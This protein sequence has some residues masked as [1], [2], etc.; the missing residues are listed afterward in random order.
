MAWRKEVGLRRPCAQTK[1]VVVGV[2]AAILD[3]GHLNVSH[4]AHWLVQRIVLVVRVVVVHLDR[5]TS[6]L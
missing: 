3:D 2:P 5:C 1:D 6:T 4:D